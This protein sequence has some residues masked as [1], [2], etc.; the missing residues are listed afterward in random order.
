MILFNNDSKSAA[1]FFAAE[2]YI[3]CDL[4]PDETAMMLWSTNNTIMIGANQITEA[5]C[6]MAYAKAADIEILRR[7]SGGGTIFT[8]RGTIQITL[9]QPFGPDDDPKKIVRK[10]IVKPVVTALERC[11]II[12]SG[13]GR[14][15]IVI[16]GK[17]ISGIAQHVKNGYICS[18]ASLL[19]SNDLDMLVR[20]L[21]VDRTKYET[22]AVASVESRVANI[23]DYISEFEIDNFLD[24]LAEPYGKKEGLQ[25]RGFDEDEL[26]QIKKIMKDKYLNPE[27]TFGREPAFT[28]TNKKRFSG[29]QIEVFLDVKG[30]TIK[31]ARITGDFLSLMPVADIEA[32]LT[33]VQHREDALEEALETI[34]IRAYMGSIGASELME[35][36]L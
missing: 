15:D 14:N 27:W 29:G 9:I 16:E 32:K 21:T 22:K 10:K 30:G 24:A 11:G 25:S 19:F 6:D 1:F 8:D 2:D 36:L 35:V 12:A 3:M 20:C 28:F 7:P 4:R 13:E 23:T 17:K 33:G 26:T 31:D 5:E 18:H 34:D